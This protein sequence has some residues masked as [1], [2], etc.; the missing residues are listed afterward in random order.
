MFARYAVSTC[1]ALRSHGELP[2]LQSFRAYSS[3]SRSAD[4]EANFQ[5][6]REWYKGFNKNTIPVKIA[7]TTFSMASGPGG[8]K[9]NKYV[10][11]N[12]CPQTLVTLFQNFFQSNNNL[13]TSCFAPSYTKGPSS[14]SERL[15]ILCALFGFH[16]NTLR[17]R[18]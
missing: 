1:S 17:C 15:S 11:V 7:K 10:D 9:T 5:A 13:A 12:I 18:S 4:D 3:H 2:V 16:P 14:R 6:A 8:Q